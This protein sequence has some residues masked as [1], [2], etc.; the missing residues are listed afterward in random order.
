VGLP[1]SQHRKI[2]IGVRA[3]G[4]PLWPIDVALKPEDYGVH[5]WVAGITKS[6]KTSY[7]TTQILGLMRCGVG[8]SFL[9]PHADAAE[10]VLARLVADGFYEQPDAF[11]RVRYI[12]FSEHEN[13][14]YLPFNV[15]D[16]PKVAPHVVASQVLEACHRAWPAL[17]GGGA[18]MFDTLVLL[19]TRVLIPNK[20]PLPALYRLLTDLAYRDG[21]LKQVSDPDV[22]SFWKDN[23]DKL[24]HSEAMNAVQSAVRRILLL[25]HSPVLRYSL[26][27]KE[28]QETPRRFM[29]DSVVSLYNLGRIQ[30]T[31]A[32]RLIGGLI[33]KGYE[34]AA[35]SRQDVPPAQRA[36][37][38]LILDEF[39]EF[40]ST[41][42]EAL[43]RTLSQTRKYGL[44]CTMACQTLSQTSKRL[45][46]ALQNAELLVAFRVGRDDAEVL[47]KR[48]FEVDVNRIKSPALSERS[49]PVFR[50]V[51]EMWEESIQALTD[52]PRRGAWMRFGNHKAVRIRTLTLHAPKVDPRRV[53]EVKEEYRRR[54]LK[55]RSE[56]V[57]DYHPATSQPQVQRVTRVKPED[58]P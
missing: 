37:H 22:I 41:T 34:D 28:N 21:L 40:S 1:F 7:L 13:G 42:E 39:A 27:A 16:Q 18:A 5:Q 52:T 56:I 2:V 49:Q 6:G 20:A 3:D 33:A 58:D 50:P 17:A 53:E 51:G 9:D 57:L 30:D 8:L 24:S 32:R 29:D 15:L 14:W 48:I 25:T 4:F 44:F 36:Q 23:F 55:H 19:G 45:Q 47:A 35:F 54:L 10:D 11:D 46:G 12:E 43:S 26:G 38:H 31:D